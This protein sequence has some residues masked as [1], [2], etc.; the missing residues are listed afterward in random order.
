MIPEPLL[1]GR[2]LILTFHRVFAQ[3]DVLRPSEPDVSE[4]ESIVQVIARHFPVYTV[5]ELVNNLRNKK[6]TQSGVAISFDDGYLDNYEL[7]Y[8]ILRKHGIKATFYVATGFLKGGIMWNDVITEGVRLLQAVEYLK[9]DHSVRASTQTASEKTSCMS[10]IV[11]IVKYLDLNQR[12]AWLESF[13]DMNALESLPSLMMEE[14]HL[15]EMHAHDMEIGGHTVSHPILSSLEK[16]FAEQE[17][18]QGK[19]F[20]E[21]LLQSDVSTFAYP[22]GKPGDY[23]S[24]HIDF[25]ERAG[26]SGAVTT[27]WGT[28]RITTEPYELPRIGVRGQ[29]RM[30]ILLRLLREYFRS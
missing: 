27:R 6:L 18:A 20:L 23:N 8:P 14:R 12:R 11:N 29:S 21:K 13:R 26:F 1:R 16:E 28:I 17:I 5:S 19:H 25:L 2:A 3:R 7:A 15:Q 22:N 10:Q 9:N 4:F 24:N 30:K